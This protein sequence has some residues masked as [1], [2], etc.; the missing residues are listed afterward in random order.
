MRV[1]Q[2]LDAQNK[3]LK[4][5]VQQQHAIA[6]E[7]ASGKRALSRLQRREFTDKVLLFLGFGLFLLVALHIVRKR[8]GSL[9]LPMNADEK[10]A[11]NVPTSRARESFACRLAQP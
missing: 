10:D 8:P 7:L 9:Y 4:D 5:V 11:W 6:K 2:S 3:V 1:A